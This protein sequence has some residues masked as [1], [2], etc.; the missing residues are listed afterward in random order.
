LLADRDKN[1]AAMKAKWTGDRLMACGTC[2]G[3]G[4]RVNYNVS[5]N[6]PPQMA[7]MVMSVNPADVSDLVQI[8]FTKEGQGTRN[9]RGPVTGQEYYFGSD[10]DESVRYVHKSDLDHFL[11]LR[12]FELYTGERELVS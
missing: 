9:Y 6:D 1:I 12:D 11:S 10:P 7:S 8:R 4:A 3:G 2:G 5:T